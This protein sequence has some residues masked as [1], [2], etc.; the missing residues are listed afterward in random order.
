MIARSCIK[1][2]L[3][4]SPSSGITVSSGLLLLRE[5]I[6]FSIA[7]VLLTALLNVTSAGSTAC[8]AQEDNSFSFIL[9]EINTLPRQDLSF[10][11][12]APLDRNVSSTEVCFFRLN[13]TISIDVHWD[14]PNKTDPLDKVYGS[15]T[16]TMLPR[17]NNDSMVLILKNSTGTFR[18][19]P[20]QV[21]VRGKLKWK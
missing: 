19:S 15:F 10:L 11:F 7:F 20:V 6:M 2:L 9:N 5:S 1:G 21:I 8:E 16:I 3:R 12:L 13:E 17:Y 18:N 4:L 14:Q